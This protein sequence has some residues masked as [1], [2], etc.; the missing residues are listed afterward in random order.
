MGR[1]PEAERGIAK[2]SDGESMHVR[3]HLP[4]IEWD[5]SVGRRHAQHFI[6]R[7][8]RFGKFTRRRSRLRQPPGT[9]SLRS[10]LGYVRLQESEGLVAISIAVVIAVPPAVTIPVPFPIP[11]MVVI[12]PAAAAFPVTVVETSALVT[13]A[14]PAGAFVRSASPIAVVPNVTMANGVPIAVH[15]N[16]IRTRPRCLPVYSWGRWRADSNSQ[17]HLTAERCASHQY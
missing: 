17:I 6:T 2:Y 3:D 14:Y 5:P 16:E 7:T 8:D 10:R 13:G 15:P 1:L 12:E 4:H 11:P 9:A